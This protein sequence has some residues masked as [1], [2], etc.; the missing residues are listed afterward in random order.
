MDEL[1]TGYYFVTATNYGTKTAM[2]TITFS[3]A[4]C[5]YNIFASLASSGK[6]N[7]SATASGNTWKE[8]TLAN[9]TTCY[10]GWLLSS[11]NVSADRDCGSEKIKITYNESNLQNATIYNL[12]VENIGSTTT[13]TSS[14]TGE[15]EEGQQATTTTTIPT[16]KYLNITSYPSIVSV[17]QGTNKTENVT[18]MNINNNLTQRVN[19]TLISVD[20]NWYSIY[21]SSVT[22]ANKSSYT[23][24]VK[25]IIPE[26]ATVKD[27][28]SAKFFAESSYGGVTKGFTLRVTPGTKLQSQI[29]ANLSTYKTE[30]QNLEKEINKTKNQNNTDAKTFFNQLKERFNQAS[31][32][33]NQS[34]YK[35][36][37]DLLSDI[38]SLLNKTKTALAMESSKS[39]SI[40]L[41]DW[42]KWVI[43][44]VIAVVAVVLGY[45]FWPTPSGGYKPQKGFLPEFKK[46]DKKTM[47]SEQL[48][49]LKEKW[50]KAQEKKE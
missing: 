48:E 49:K 50:R 19:L 20:S 41:G 31:N 6:T 27:Y 26:N 40:N 4:T 12:W 34:E 37:Y 24:T 43:I 5:Q 46:E 17:T 23:Y 7:C 28:S 45:L 32:Y 3:N 39:I 10:F 18:V 21:P 16:V 36:A 38:E 13:T 44:G 15:E 42:G 9:G 33:Y 8:I 2:G 35:S 14:S 29:S 47:I 11:F 30:I 22:I 25:F 1:T